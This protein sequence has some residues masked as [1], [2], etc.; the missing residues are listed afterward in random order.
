MALNNPILGTIPQ[1][2]A[3]TSEIENPHIPAN[4]YGAPQFISMITNKPFVLTLQVSGGA[5]SETD[6]DYN[7]E[8]IILTQIN[9]N[10]YHVRSAG[11]STLAM[12]LYINELHV[13]SWDSDIPDGGLYPMEQVIPIQNWKIPSNSQFKLTA[14][15]TGTGGSKTFNATFIGYTPPKV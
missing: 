14:V 7:T 13:W 11:G 10:G 5:S 2:K 4:N 1:P 6:I 3:N 12:N 8:D 15:R 9:I